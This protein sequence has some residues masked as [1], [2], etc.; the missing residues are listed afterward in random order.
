MSF[1]SSTPP[2]MPPKKSSVS[3]AI[4]AAALFLG[5]L[6][7]AADPPDAMTL[8]DG[9]KLIGKVVRATGAGVT[10]HSDS[11]GD[12]TVP[13][14]KIK[15]LTT[16]R[17]FAVIPK[18]VQFKRKESESKIPRGTLVFT[19]GKIQVTPGA[20][21]PAQTLATADTGFIID[22]DA[23]QK[24]LHNPG[25]GQ[26]WKGAVTGGISLIEATQKSET[27]T[28]SAHLVRAIP[29]EDWLSARNRT[30]VNFTASYG[31]VDQ[32][33]TPEVKTDLVHFDFERDEYFSP[34]VY[35]LGQAAFDHN[36]SQGLSLQQTYSG[37]AGWTALKS[38][39][40]TLDLKATLSYISQRFN[41]AS[42]KDLVGSVFGEEYHRNL[43]AGIKFDEQL[44]LIP[45]YNNTSAYS[46]NAGAGV[47]MA[48]Y[49]RLS[50]N[51]ST[52]DT[53][54]NDPPPGFKKNSYQFT[55]GVTYSL[56]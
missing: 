4:L 51:I 35:A 13:W 7:H 33:N 11:A 9:E 40:Q 48:L 49:K 29:I 30:L 3:F 50:L 32:P 10:F 27:F 28:G 25:L 42:N 15:E 37:G 1:C 2:F 54:L 19:D 12:V 43:P 45:A 36:F 6:A 55:T 52:L 31:K 38:D 18:G 47:T 14:A 46:A 20:G 23:Y 17:R 24:A 56:P 41:G 26:D 39:K 8:A 44:T 53:F 34:R 21:Q 22:E 5:A 16:A